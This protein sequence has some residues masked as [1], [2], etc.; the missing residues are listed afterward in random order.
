MENGNRRM[1]KVD[2]EKSGKEPALS[3]SKG[4]RPSLSDP[5]FPFSPFSLFPFPPS[6]FPFPSLRLRSGQA[7]IFLFLFVVQLSLAGC[8]V[9]PNLPLPTTPT[10]TATPQPTSTATPKPTATPTAT[11][12]P[13]PTPTP[14]IVILKTPRPRDRTAPEP[15][16]AGD[17]IAYSDHLDFYA[18]SDNYWRQH[19]DN[20]GPAIEGELLRVA[21]RLQADLPESRIPVSIQ[22]PSTS[23]LVRGMDCPA[24]GLYYGPTSG[25]PLLTIFADESTSRVQVLAVAAH[26]LA[27]H[28]TQTKFGDGGD[29]L[30]SEGLANWASR[31]TWSLW[32]GWPSFD[33]AVREYRRLDIYLPLDETL[34]FDPD[35]AGELGLSDC[36]ALRDLRYNEWSSFV[37]YLIDRYGFAIIAELWSATLEPR[38]LLDR[39]RRPGAAPTV[40]AQRRPIPGRP[41][42]SRP[43]RAPTVNYASV[44]GKDLQELEQ[45]WL[46]SLDRL[47][48]RR[49]RRN[50][51]YAIRTNSP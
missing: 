29:V 45:D 26:E 1:E 23:P 39:D 16:P 25:T 47:Q 9:L 17:L 49:E 2:K 22:A 28:L 8:T 11:Q 51:Q 14:A 46:Q 4:K 31:D 5:L 24:R 10:P 34:N 21:G 20:I 44:L 12:T 30:L 38:P 6:I 43:E 35:I 15:T 19:I 48:A 13:T 50:T 27:H 32:Q 41:V 40:P 18:E 33:A 3:L 37:N 7:S 36:L 42:P